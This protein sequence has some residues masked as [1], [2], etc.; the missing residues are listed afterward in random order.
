MGIIYSDYAK[1]EEI[2]YKLEENMG[3]D[4]FFKAYGALKDK[5]ED[6]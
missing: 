4:N 5:I 2:K 6:F 3:F 1:L